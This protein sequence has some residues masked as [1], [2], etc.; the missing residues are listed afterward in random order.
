MI[1]I[2]YGDTVPITDLEIIYVITFSLFACGVFGYAFNTIG[3]IFKDMAQKEA[4][5]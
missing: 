2:G 3:N 4:E 5:Y 1:T